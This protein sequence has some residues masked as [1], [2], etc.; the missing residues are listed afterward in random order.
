ME[1]LSLLVLIA[2]LFMVGSLLSR[3]NRL[4]ATLSTLDEKLGE[5]AFR[6]GRI[7]AAPAPQAAGAPVAAIAPEP[8]PAPQPVVLRE[9]R[10]EP[11]VTQAPAPLSEP[12]A[13][14]DDTP[15]PQPALTPEE[16]AEVFPDEPPAAPPDVPAE[17]RDYGDFERRFGTQWVVWIGGL[18]LALGAIFLVRYSIEAGLFTPKLRVIFGAIFA[19][20]LVGLGELARRREIQSGISQI[21]GA[22]IP[23]IL[24]AAGTTAAYADI[25]AAYALY[26]FLPPAIAFVLLGLVALATLAAALVHGQGLAG[27]GL[28]GAYVTPLLVSTAQPNYWALYIYLA[29]VTAA[30]YALARLRLWRWL[31]ITAAVFSLFWMLPGLMDAKAIGAHAFHAVAGFA[32]AS[33][34]IVAGFLYGPP[35]ERGRYDMVSSWILAGYLLAAFLL[36][37]VNRHDGLAVLTL[38]VLCAATIAVAWRSEAAT[39]VIAA[40]ALAGLLVIVHWSVSQ[41]FVVLHQPGGVFSSVPPVAKLE[42]LRTHL[43]FGAGLAALFGG[44]GF[45]MQG[46]V[47]HPYSAILWAAASVL[48]PVITLVAL[49]YGVAHFE[50]SIPFAA[51]ALLLAALF[52]VATEMLNRRRFAPGGA[53]ATAIYACGA[54]AALALALAFALER[55]WLTVALALMV[56]GIAFIAD[57]R[58]LPMLRELCIVLVVLVMARI[59]WDPRI[60]GDDVGKTPIFNWLLWG[61]GVP[62]L[63]FWIGGIILR[64]RADD[65]ASRCVDSAAITFTALALML[66]IRHFMND[67]DIYRPTAGL[68]E[69]G[70]QVATGLAMTIGLERVR[71][72]TGSIVHDIAARIIG[73]LAF[74]GILISLGIHLNP[75]FTGEPVGGVFFNTLLLGYGIPAMLMAILARMIRG[76]RPELVYR[77]AAVTAIALA[78][79][80]LTLEVRTIFHGPVI[81]GFRTS[82]AEQYTYSAV[83]LAFGVALLLTGIALK[84]A[85]ARFASAAVVLLTVAKVFLYDLAGV[86]G[87]FRALS[88]ICLGLTLMGIGWL[89][90]RLLFPPQRRTENAAQDAPA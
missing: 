72:R 36:V 75:I 77:I 76:T 39:P 90:Q 43:L 30:A 18:A 60:V 52:A 89:Y 34:F 32:L 24:T 22:D 45:W 58:P 88:L 46:R 9:A 35:A 31:A 16:R 64:R 84:S 85:P 5:L 70:L 10:D 50:R 68:G 12:A 51:L 13:T 7:A 83:W 71:E 66:Q 8:E 29:V 57:K 33:A 47:A 53:A 86:Q 56:P 4:D 2:L 73:I 55:G 41:Y 59:V 1:F 82:D 80:Y 44:A 67:G 27:L 37:F 15:A 20:F 74:L 40:A 21:K 17:P 19:L 14:P 63:S 25:W 48:V 42:G 38:F 11:V 6:A 79:V 87:F 49:N 54:V 81:K 3:V 26:D 23:S 28:I 62:A 61:Y 65:L 69:V 78:L